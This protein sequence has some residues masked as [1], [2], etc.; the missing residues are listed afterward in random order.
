L[1][2]FDVVTCP[3]CNGTGVEADEDCLLCRGDGIVDD[4]AA[5]YRK[6]TYEIPPPESA[7]DRHE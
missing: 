4:D 5:N 6:P 1:N 3:R 2:P 7:L